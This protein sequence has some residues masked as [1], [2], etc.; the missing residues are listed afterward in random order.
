MKYE[1]DNLVSDLLE[2]GTGNGT[3]SVGVAPSSGRNVA[4]YVQSSDPFTVP[5]ITIPPGN[6]NVTSFDADSLNFGCVRGHG[7]GSAQGVS[8]CILE[9]NGYRNSQKVASQ[10]FS[11]LPGLVTKAKMTQAQLTTA[12]RN[13]ERVEFATTYHSSVKEGGATYIDDVKFTAHERA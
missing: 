3:V 2:P 11:F 7:G 12:F 1:T 10:K 13:L 5:F 6:T 9:V 4:A 8:V